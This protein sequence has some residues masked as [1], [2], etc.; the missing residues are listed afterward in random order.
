MDVFDLRRRSGLYLTYYPH[1]DTRRRGVAL[2]AL[3]GR[4]GF[5]AGTRRAGSCHHPPVVL[6]FAALAGPGAREAPPRRQRR[7]LE[8]IHRALADVGSPYAAL[9]A[10]LLSLLPPATPADLAAVA[11]LAA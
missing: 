3:R 2:L 10:A 4:T 9:L 11:K 6:E 5:A 7:G 1:G 8:L